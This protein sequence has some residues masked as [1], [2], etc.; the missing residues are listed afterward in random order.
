MCQF[1]S[2]F[3]NTL[4]YTYIFHFKYNKLIEP[5]F[6]KL[7]YQELTMLYITVP[8]GR[9][10]VEKKHEKSKSKKY[11]GIIY[12]NVLFVSC[13]LFQCHHMKRTFFYI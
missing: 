8:D 5:C 7:Q 6:I 4:K 10:P 11:L 9:D 3:C 2:I 1:Y 12:N 13:T